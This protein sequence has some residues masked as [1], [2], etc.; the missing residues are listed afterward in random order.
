MAGA[1]AV[2][3]LLAMALLRMAA[4][5]TAATSAPGSP[6]DALPGQIQQGSLLRAH[7]APGS[8]L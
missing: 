6:L 3:R 8:Q 5:A 2:S 4:G 7:V 1:L